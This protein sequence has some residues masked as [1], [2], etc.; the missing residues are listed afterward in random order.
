MFPVKVAIFGQLTS[1]GNRICITSNTV[2]TNLLNTIAEPKEA[3]Q[4]GESKLT[5]LGTRK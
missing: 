3:Q 2:G 1:G 4:Y 5:L